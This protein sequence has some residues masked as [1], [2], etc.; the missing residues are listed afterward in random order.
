VTAT[1]TEPT[2]AEL[3]EWLDLS[4]ERIAIMQLAIQVDALP[5]EK[6]REIREYLEAAVVKAGPDS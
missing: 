6:M 1:A 5:V 4:Y 2:R 3:T